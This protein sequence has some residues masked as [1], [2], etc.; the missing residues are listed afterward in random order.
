M[1]HHENTWF[2][3]FYTLQTAERV[4]KETCGEK[5][6]GTFLGNAPVGYLKYKYPPAQQDKEGVVGA[7]VL[8]TS[9]LIKHVYL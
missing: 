2:T 6:S 4:L 3:I 1:K 8:A 5:I 7:K 9:A